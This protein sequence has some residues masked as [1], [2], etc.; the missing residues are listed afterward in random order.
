MEGAFAEAPEELVASD[1]DT[2]DY[3]HAKLLQAIGNLDGK[4]R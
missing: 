3:K 2:D 4:K 1:D